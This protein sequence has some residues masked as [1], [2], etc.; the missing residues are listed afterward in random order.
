ML[1]LPC[2]VSIVEY[3]CYLELLDTWDPKS[4]PKLG[5]DWGL[6]GMTGIIS[7]AGKCILM[8][9]VSRV[10]V[11]WANK[12]RILDRTLTRYLKAASV[13]MDSIGV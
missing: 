7:G 2:T 3:S 12:I 13:D 6:I 8:K 1:G 10:G 5:G 11:S 4:S 9:T